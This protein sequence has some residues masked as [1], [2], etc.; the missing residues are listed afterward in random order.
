M[1]WNA[2]V[3]KRMGEW[4]GALRMGGVKKGKDC[5]CRMEKKRGLKEGLWRGREGEG[6]KM[7]ERRG[8][9]RERDASRRE[10]RGV[11]LR[12]F[13]MMRCVPSQRIGLVRL[14]KIY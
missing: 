11:M 12:M 10:V 14:E 7:E 9:V 3:G 6:W 13:D 5:R 8:G 4:R 2:V 1:Y